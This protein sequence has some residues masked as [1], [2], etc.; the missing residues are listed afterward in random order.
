MYVQNINRET[1]KNMSTK[2]FVF[3]FFLCCISTSRLHAQWNWYNP[4][5]C[6][7]FVIQNQGWKN[8]IG[9][10]YVRLPQRAERN[11]RTDVWN[12]SRQSAGLSICFRTNASEIK[13]R[14]TVK[15]C[16]CLSH[17]PTTGVSGMDLYCINHNGKWGRL[18]GG[19][20]SGDTL[21]YHYR[22][23][24]KKNEIKEF[25]L[26]LPLYNSVDWLE[27]GIPKGNSLT[28]IPA[29]TEKPIVVYGTSIVQGACASRP[30]M[31]W[32]NILQRSLNLPV[33]NLGFSGNG[34][35]EKDVISY[36]NEIDA[37]L[38]ILDCL[39]NLFKNP[40]VYLSKDEAAN[41]VFEAV[42][43]IRAKHNSPILLIEHTGYSDASVDRTQYSRYTRLNKGAK[44]A[45]NK[46]ISKGIKHIYYLSNNELNI[47]D[48]MRV[49]NVHLSDWGMH[50]QAVKV[51]EKVRTI[52][53][54]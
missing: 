27:I 44:D 39:P 33:I 23:I 24:W 51:E 1:M 36:I 40:H 10:S 19:K 41:L 18:D 8:E 14:Y 25:R 16:L 17:M 32:T 54:K 43:Q 31:A 12:L 6:D 47:L 53:D 49:D 21:R 42:M 4:L 11:V 38:F 30:G 50:V 9:K 46:L 3:L 37:C 22:N 28:F 13:V 52:L 2:S 7:S 26:F 45:F 34:R 5:H 29:S 20:P 15:G 35:L 48:E